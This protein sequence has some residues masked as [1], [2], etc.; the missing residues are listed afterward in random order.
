MAGEV[1]R[2]S[3]GT[4]RVG[5]AEKVGE[6]V[7]AR[8]A[9]LN[10]IN[11]DVLAGVV[12]ALAGFEERPELRAVVIR[13]EGRCFSAGGDLAEVKELVRDPVRYSEFLD[14]W[15]AGL[16]AVENSPLPV[17]AAVHG[18]AFAGGLELI[19]VCDL[20]VVGDSTRIGDQ[21]AKFGL[22]PAGG[23]T[24]RLPRLVGRR[25]ASWML[26]SGEAV[27]PAEAVALGL[28]NRVVP[29]GEVVAEAHRMAE[30]LASRSRGA[31]AAI[32]RAVR[33]GAERVLSDA[34]AIERPIVLSHMASDDAQAGI[35]AFEAR[36]EPRF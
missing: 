21:H 15:H 30:V 1:E 22:F 35:A 32:K 23:S 4:V 14:R 10:A 31:T 17:I 28:A 6:I 29:E 3:A 19:Q 34:I 27:T 26:M 33:A 2:A 7:L 13:G 8:P 24:Q 5:G 20:A 12:A 18:F 9:K 36:T 11:S 25:A 16:A